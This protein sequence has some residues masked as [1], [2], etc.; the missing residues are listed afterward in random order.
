MLE[1]VAIDYEGAGGAVCR[2]YGRGRGGLEFFRQLLA[3]ARRQTDEA[4]LALCCRAR[5]RCTTLNPHE[6][7]RLA[8]EVPF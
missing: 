2:V 5:P 8:Y 3:K 6:S 1:V 7:D 4:F